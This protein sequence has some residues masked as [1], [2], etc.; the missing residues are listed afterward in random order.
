MHFASCCE[1]A[2][3]C[4]RAFHP[5]VVKVPCRRCR[6]Q[7]FSFTSWATN[8]KVSPNACIA[9]YATA[10]VLFFPAPTGTRGNAVTQVCPLL[11]AR[12]VLALVFAAAMLD[13]EY[14]G[15]YGY[16]SACLL[17]TW[18]PPCLCS[19]L[20]PCLCSRLPPYLRSQFVHLRSDASVLS[21]VLC[22]FVTMLCMCASCMFHCLCICGMRCACDVNSACGAL[23][24]C[25][26]YALG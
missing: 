9:C 2:K 24:A 15:T 12:F 10:L 8:R 14:T 4:C 20:P 26:E 25:V 11:C 13:T 19:R 17:C 5:R 1:G 3:V 7:G 22:M 18:L 23:Y 21:C 6:S 16:V